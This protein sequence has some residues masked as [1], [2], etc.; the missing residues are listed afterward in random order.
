MKRFRAL[1]FRLGAASPNEIKPQCI[2]FYRWLVQRVTLEDVEISPDNPIDYVPLSYEDIGQNN[3][4][5]RVHAACTAAFAEGRS[6]VDV[7]VVD[8]EGPASL[9]RSHISIQIAHAVSLAIA[10][11]D[12]RTD[13]RD[14]QF[15]LIQHEL[16]PET[17]SSRI[18]LAQH[19][20]SGRVAIF[21]HAGRSTLGKQ[22]PRRYNL[23]EFRLKLTIAQGSP[24]AL[25]SRKMIRRV[26]RFAMRGRKGA[27]ECSRFFYD[28]RY[29]EAEIASLLEDEIVRAGLPDDCRICY[30]CPDS[31]WLTAPAEA[32]AL[33]LGLR[34]T[35]LYRI[36]SPSA[37][38]ADDY[39]LLLVDCMVT[40][41]T[42]AGLLDRLLDTGL[43]SSRVYGV[44]VLAAS[45]TDFQSHT[46]RMEHRGAIY[47]VSYF[48]AIEN[49]T[50]CDWCEQCPGYT[51][52]QEEYL[53][54][55]AD[56][57]W[58]MAIAA[59][60]KR[61][62]DVPDYRLGMPVV[63]DYPQV[64]DKNAPWLVSKMGVLLAE[65]GVEIPGSNLFVCPLDE[66][67][68]SVL[69]ECLSL[70]LNL[71]VVGIPR[72]T[73]DTFG[74]DNEPLREAEWR[75]IGEK[76]PI[77]YVRLG[78]SVGRVGLLDEFNAS[79]RT[80]LGLRR[81]VERFG[82]DVS[83]MLVLNDLNPEWSEHQ[84]VNVL[85]LYGWQSY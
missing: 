46:R 48:M 30:W 15:I 50:E 16:P 9:A 83:C 52:R 54:L 80:L 22:S 23:E 57:H 7:F 41:R 55:T 37:F 12:D 47:E 13:K 29:C 82:K 77:W 45:P 81:V 69:A 76:R 71:D 11:E 38:G 39:V 53:R 66:H 49:G 33:R 27:I 20:E 74:S 56:E 24:E 1:Q 61:E 68:S 75:R 40:G 19:L 35:D 64:V 84:D 73:V 36:E 58:E 10:E 62:E 78:G 34:A 3:Q 42:F 79:G 70:L 26:G 6:S 31:P 17:E 14:M 59:G 85:S 32:V 65:E 67:G 4:C 5:T 2:A 44:T 72:E 43:D 51:N 21:S 28:G 18:I 63:I 25:L 60:V 8:V